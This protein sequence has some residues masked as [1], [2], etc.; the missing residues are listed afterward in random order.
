MDD[1]EAGWRTLPLRKIADPRGNLTPIE[2]GVDIPFEVARVYYLYDVPSGS[3]RAGHAH[4]TLRQV[5]IALSG[6]FEVKLEDARSTETLAL[7]RPDSGLLIGP[8]VW[9]EIENFSSGAVC[10]VLASARFDEADYIRDYAAFK[11]FVAT[12]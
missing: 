8:G 12:S 9:R 6:S 5:Y 7:N 1:S 11:R 4:R 10:L 2:S 3:M